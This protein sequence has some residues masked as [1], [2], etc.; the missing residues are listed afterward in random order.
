MLATLRT[1]SAASLS[2][3]CRRI[4][5]RK[6]V[7]IAIRPIDSPKQQQDAAASEAPASSGANGNGLVIYRYGN[8]VV[9]SLVRRYIRF[10]AD[11][12]MQPAGTAGRGTQPHD[13]DYSAASASS[14]SGNGAADATAAT[15]ATVVHCPNTG[16]LMGVLDWP[17]SP[18]RCSVSSNST[19]KYQ[20]TLVRRTCALALHADLAPDFR[21]K[22]LDCYC[23]VEL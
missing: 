15:A 8:L 23:S 13:G 21:Q 18:V 1:S 22:V 10:L 20:H 19:R 2:F 4:M 3:A 7:I 11:V 6:P 17:M 14:S 12:V 5:G 16:S 9:G